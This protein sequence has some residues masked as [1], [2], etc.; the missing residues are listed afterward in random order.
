VREI[1]E[2][3]GQSKAETIKKGFGIRLGG[4]RQ[5]RLGQQKGARRS[6]AEIVPGGKEK[7][8]WRWGEEECRSLPTKRK[9]WRIK[10]NNFVIQG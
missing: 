7:G 5:R 8:E 6:R 1:Q 9:Y 10:K 3:K 4:E 2:E